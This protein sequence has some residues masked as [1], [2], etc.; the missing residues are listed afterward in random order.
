[1]KRTREKEKERQ[2]ARR[3]PGT[4]GGVERGR[5]I[6]R[7]RDGKGYREEKEGRGRSQSHMCEKENERGE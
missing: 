5:E 6:D 4:A 2:G 1:M 7:G 3:R